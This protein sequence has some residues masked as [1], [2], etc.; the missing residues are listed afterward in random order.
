[1]FGAASQA[2]S[3]FGAASQAPSMFGASAGFGVKSPLGVTS[4]A[5][6]A[7]GLG[8]TAFASNINGQQVASVA[9]APAAESNFCGSPYG[10]SIPLSL[11]TQRSNDE[12]AQRAAEHP[13]LRNV[14]SQ[15]LRRRINTPRSSAA[16][17]PLATPSVDHTAAPSHLSQ[18]AAPSPSPALSQPPSLYH[19]YEGSAAASPADAGPRRALLLRKPQFARSVSEKLSD[20]AS[21]PASPV[22]PVATRALEG[23]AFGSARPA[24]EISE[25]VQSPS[26]SISSDIAF[27]IPEGYR[28]S[29]SS[30]PLTA[31]SVRSVA[32]STMRAVKDVLIE[33]PGKGS[34]LFL[35][36]VD[37]SR[38]IDLAKAVCISNKEVEVYPSGCENKPEPGSG[39]NL[40]ARVTLHGV[41]PINKTTRE[42]E[43][44]AS[45]VEKFSK[46]I[47]ENTAKMGAKFIG[48]QA[49]TG[50]W[51][52]EVDHF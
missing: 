47:K 37:F 5:P 10:D 30:G 32:P 18:S 33:H 4:L 1:M 14:L 49:A 8:T 13:I 22:V 48:Y 23:S 34:I 46:K 15:P 16:P 12:G 29:C 3:L 40:P 44:D 41:F 24:A 2:P 6:T 17:S 20:P 11:P 43:S 42:K 38:G 35:E 19:A 9:L 26:Y 50:T 45:V 36:P 28:L 39:I 27:S 21:A 52:F 7:I 25:M 51:I 31:A